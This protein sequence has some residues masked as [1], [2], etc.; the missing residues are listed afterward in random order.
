MNA[1]TSESIDVMERRAAKAG[2]AERRR[3]E[4]HRFESRATA[5]CLGGQHFGEIHA[6]KTYDYS[7]C[8]FCALSRTPIEPGSAVT[9]GFEYQGFSA[10]RGKVLRCEAFEVGYRVAVHFE[11]MP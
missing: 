10:E 4:R 2:L 9:V 8:G 1:T 7:N 11:G 5:F 3:A 6:L